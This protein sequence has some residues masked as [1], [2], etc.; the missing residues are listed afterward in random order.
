MVAALLKTSEGMSRDLLWGLADQLTWSD[1]TRQK[2]PLLCAQL[3]GLQT[4]LQTSLKLSA[5]YLQVFVDGTRKT[6]APGGLLKSPPPLRQEK[7]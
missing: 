7:S 3:S 6:W 5:R 2:F 4:G 1:L